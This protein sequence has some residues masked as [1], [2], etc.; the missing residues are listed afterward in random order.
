MSAPLAAATAAALLLALPAPVQAS[1]DDRAF[2]VSL[3][4]GTFSIPDHSPDGGVVGV[5]YERGISESIALRASGGAGAYYG[6]GLAYSAHASIGLTYAFDVIKYVP[7]AN[8]GVGGIVIDGSDIDADV[9]PL[10]ELGVGLD[11]LKSREF[12]WGFQARFETYAANTSFFTAGTRLT[13]RW[14]F[15]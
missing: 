4:Y 3:A 14:G 2:S 11:I 1:E 6:S 7:Y 12:S 5:D 8:L 15:F 13:W 9:Y 10:L